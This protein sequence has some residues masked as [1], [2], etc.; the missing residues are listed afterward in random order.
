MFP[1]PWKIFPSS[2]PLS[3]IVESIL[4][5]DY[6]DSNARDP[7][8][9]KVVPTTTPALVV[10]YRPQTKA[11][12]HWQFGAKSFRHNGNIPSATKLHSGIVT[13]HPV[14][15]I[16]AFIIAL[17]PAAAMRI[18][19]ACLDQFFDT[20]V[21]L[22][23]LVGHGE[24]ALLQEM[25]AEAGGRAERLAHL[26]RFL[27]RW[28]RYGQPDP[29]IARAVGLLRRAP[30]SPMRRLAT[31]LDISERQFRRRFQSVIGS[32][33]K[34]FARIA[35]LRKLLALRGRGSAWAQAAHACG[36]QDQAHL[37]HDFK[38][39]TGHAPDDLLGGAVQLPG[40]EIISFLGRDAAHAPSARGA[41]SLDR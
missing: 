4:D 20:R 27:T 1:P 21:P 24:L 16:G 17:K 31:S 34:Q 10:V 13:I 9:M 38:D 28:V 18:M 22:A 33:P 41:A 8:T 39:I 23:D 26:E 35:R 5:M 19:G 12:V 37:I 7:L 3:E 32:S 6:P 2:P 29:V 14:G 36:Y 15:P 11:D 30:S 25:L 40:M